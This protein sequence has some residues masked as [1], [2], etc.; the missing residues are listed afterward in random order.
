MEKIIVVDDEE[1]NL[2][3]LETLFKAHGYQVTTARNGIKAL[4]AA[5]ETPPDIII[6]DALMPVMDGFMLCREWKSDSRLKNIP[7]IFYT[8]TY[9][10]P[11]DEK[12]ALDLGCDLFIVK[13]QE[14]DVLVGQIQK[15]LAKYKEE[16]MKM[17]SG[18]HGTGEQILQQHN[19]TLF[20]KLEKKIK[21]LEEANQTIKENETKYRSI[22]EN[23]IAG[24]FRT[25]PEGRFLTLNPAFCR[26]TG[27][28]SPEELRSLVTNI[29]EQMYFRLED[30]VDFLQQLNE[31]NRAEEFI[32]RFRKKDGSV[33]WVTINGW[34]VRD[35][36]NNVLYYEGM[37]EDITD[38]ILREE[39]LKN[40]MM[41]T[42]SI[43]ATIVEERDPYTA[44]HQR[45]VSH[46]ASSIAEELNL[47]PLQVEGVR[48]AGLIHDVGKISIPAEI[49]SKPGRLSIIELS[50]VKVHAEAGFNILKDV[51]F[52]W[53][54]A[55]A[56]H[57]H[58][59]RINGSGYP[60]GLKDGGIIIEA[61]IIGV[62]DVAEAMSSH[63]PY[64]PALGI[65][66]ALNEIE[67]N[68]GILYDEDVAK[69]CI[70]LF[71][72][73]NYKIIH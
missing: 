72:N 25:T 66:A 11:K 63:R 40:S 15:V 60:C 7:L 31:N 50:L 35:E 55:E 38:R 36:N 65:D 20:R 32:T 39:K 70:N 44:G 10:D 42:I 53:P 8:A 19:E 52:A 64:R 67:N 48:I 34:T 43:I 46:L 54:V 37:I 3:Y 57:Q 23:S 4:E 29:G 13:P 9:T 16:R 27:Y 58:H 33:I 1:Q 59:E 24:I 17:S 30:R 26:M 12:L 62:A 21:Q 2:A 47:S 61:R 41:G 51:E 5:R 14:P 69:A 56:I 18:N 68:A 73:K 22:F 49:L 28:K 6:T 71:R 45:R